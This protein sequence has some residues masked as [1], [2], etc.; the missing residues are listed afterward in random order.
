MDC[1]GPEDDSIL[2]FLWMLEKR[3]CQVWPLHLV[4]L[5]LLGLDSNPA[6]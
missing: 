1:K 3:V 2:P 5:T 6:D 4:K